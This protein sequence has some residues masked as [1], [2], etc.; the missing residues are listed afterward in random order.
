[1]KFLIPAMG[2]FVITV[3]CKFPDYANQ[4]IQS[5]NE[6]V[7][8]LLSTEIRMEQT[9]LKICAAFLEKVGLKDNNHADFLA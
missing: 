4:Q 1:M 9:A 2:T 6:I 8:H 3:I 5:I 7:Q